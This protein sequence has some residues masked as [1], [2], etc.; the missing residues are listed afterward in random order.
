LALNYLPPEALLSGVR[1]YPLLDVRTPAEFALGHI[2]GAMNLPLFTN[3]ERAEVG[4]LYKQQSPEAAFLRGLELAGSHMRWY[5]EEA[6]RLAPEKK[7]RLHCWRGGQRSSSLGWLLQQAGFQVEVVE[8]GYKAFRQAGRQ[9]L[10]NW[11][12]PLLILGG[13][14][15]AAKTEVL[16]VLARRGETVVDLEGLANHK[17]S[18]FGA[19]GEEPQPTVEQFENDLFSLFASLDPDDHRP[20]WLENES[21]AIGRVYIPQELWLK[22]RQS[23]LLILDTPLEWRVDHLVAVYAR[24]SRQELVESFERISKRLGGQHVQA[25]LDALKAND[26]ATAARIALRYYD[27]AYAYSL[28]RSGM[29]VLDRLVPT[30]PAPEAMAGLLLQWLAQHPDHPLL[31]DKK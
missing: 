14:T 21:R 17:G 16:K 8:G 19:L 23:P 4:T 15:G 6:M 30:D 10:S 26:H 3:E 12:R 5:V 11:S 9:L 22:M 1:S 31:S 25:A 18:S 7:V 13:P 2:P 27:K 28:E 29:P 24:A 20:V